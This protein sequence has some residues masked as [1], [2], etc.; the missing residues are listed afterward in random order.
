MDLER[1]ADSTFR[2]ENLPRCDDHSGVMLLRRASR[3]GGVVGIFWN[4]GLFYQFFLAIIVVV[5]SQLKFLRI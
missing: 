4:F 2:K 1:R 5:H 3:K